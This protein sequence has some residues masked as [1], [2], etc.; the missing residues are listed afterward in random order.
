MT[1]RHYR[2]GAKYLGAYGGV[3]LGARPL[4]GA[5]ECPVPN[6]GDDVW[7]E[8]SGAW[9]GAKTSDQR[10]EAEVDADIALPL[11]AALVKQLPDPVLFR[12]DL[13]Q[14]KKDERDGN[15]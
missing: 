7:D 5:V 1:I 4:S 11:I 12:A 14:L 10:V 2:K 15:R 9:K 3:G 13:L 6:R 8:A